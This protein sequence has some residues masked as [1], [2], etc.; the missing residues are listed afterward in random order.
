MRKEYEITQEELDELLEASEPTP[1]MYASGGRPM[2]S[3]PQENANRA[4]ARLGEKLKFD[5]MTAKPTDKGNRFFT[6]ESRA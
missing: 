3:S 4:W 1:V 6:A 2:F 5:Y